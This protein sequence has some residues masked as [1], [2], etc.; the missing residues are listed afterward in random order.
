MKNITPKNLIAI[1]ALAIMLLGA[2]TTFA[3]VPGVWDPQPRVDTHEAGFTIIAMPEDEPSYYSHPTTTQ[4]Q[5]QNNTT[6]TT[7]TTT[8]QTSNN[9]TTTPS[10]TTVKSN[11][12]SSNIP[13]VVTE[14]TGSNELTAL[15]FQGN[16]GFLP[17]SFWQWLAVVALILVIIIIFRSFKKPEQHH[18][19]A[20]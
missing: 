10:R 4:N 12:S 3:Y 7:T 5:T 18:A 16:G 1:S 17:S 2:Q 11:T 6:T 15:S 14:P 9:H 13:P 19:P 20:H 8:H